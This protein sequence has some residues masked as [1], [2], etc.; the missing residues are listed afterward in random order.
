MGQRRATAVH[1]E[2]LQNENCE[3]LV[4]IGDDCFRKLLLILKQWGWAEETPD[5]YSVSEL[6]QI[7]DLFRRRWITVGAK[8]P[9]LSELVGR[10]ASVQDF[11]HTWKRAKRPLSG[12]ELLFCRRATD[13]GPLFENLRNERNRLYHDAEAIGSE[14][15]AFLA[16]TVLMLVAVVGRQVEIEP[17]RL[18]ALSACSRYALQTLYAEGQ[19]QEHAAPASS[20]VPAPS[21]APVSVPPPVEEISEPLPARVSSCAAEGNGLFQRIESGQQDLCK[22]IDRLPGL[23]MSLLDERRVSG[24][25][26]SVL[27]VPQDD[28]MDLELPSAGVSGRRQALRALRDRI[29][30]ETGVDPWENICQLPI[31]DALLRRKRDGFPV[32][33][34]EDLFDTPEFR[35]KYDRHAAVMERLLGKYGGELLRLL[36]D[37]GG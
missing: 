28:G 33:R 30:D 37:S 9:E 4:E 19:P 34:R 35:R 5:P 18:D 25:R 12:S 6:R 21:A 22:Q 1:E 26:P 36:G 7:P 3:T 23:L 32:H 20:Q 8:R 10:P 27:D 31:V 16:S 13:I 14:H 15:A 11:G 24:T 2:L 29:R 17:A